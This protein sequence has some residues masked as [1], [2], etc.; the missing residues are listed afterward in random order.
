MSL[1]IGI[2]SNLL[3]KKHNLAMA[4][5]ELSHC[6]QLISE[7]QIYSSKAQDYLEQPDFFNQVLE[8]QSPKMEPEKVLEILISIEKKLGRVRDIP[9][10][11]RIIDLDILFFDNL[12]FKNDSLEIPHPRSFKRSFVIRPLSELPG[13]KKLQENY[14]FDFHFDEDAFP[15]QN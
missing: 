5:K 10:G 3:D 11:P 13:F 9:K 6:F 12:S 1:F 8:F 2:G 14:S 15:V 7:S 4:K